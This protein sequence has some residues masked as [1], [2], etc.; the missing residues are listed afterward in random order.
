MIRSLAVLAFVAA[1]LGSVAA[2][3]IAPAAPA[4]PSAADIVVNPAAVVSNTPKQANMLTGLYATRAVIELCSVTIEPDVLSGI[5]ADQARLEQS[6]NMDTPTG[7]TAYAK[8]KADVEKTSPDCAEGSVDRASVDAVVSIYANQP[9]APVAASPAAP[10]AG[11]VSATP[12]APAAPATP[13]T[14]AQ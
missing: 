11:T 13:A 3:E 6:L 12:A 9:A 8:V 1:G 10:T 5:E 14:P 7:A 4:A 2:Q